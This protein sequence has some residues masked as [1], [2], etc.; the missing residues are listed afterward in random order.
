MRSP[1]DTVLN[2]V[3]GGAGGERWSAD[4]GVRGLRM[5]IQGGDGTMRDDAVRDVS[6]RM[7]THLGSTACG[8]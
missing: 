3:W 8:P 4:R 2:G 1:V 6:C 5:E 7:E